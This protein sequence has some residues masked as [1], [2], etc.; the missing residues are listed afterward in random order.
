MEYCHAMPQL[1]NREYRRCEIL[2]QLRNAPERCGPGA[3]D[4]RCARSACRS[5]GSRSPCGT[6]RTGSADRTCG[7]RRTS[8]TCS[9]GP[10][11]RP[12]TCGGTAAIRCRP[13]AGCTAIALRRRTSAAVRRSR[14]SQCHHDTPNICCRRNEQNSPFDQLH[15]LSDPYRQLMLDDHPTHLDDSDDCA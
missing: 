10:A 15:R 4:A 6:C 13:A 5:R 14:S 9:S 12:A 3:R 7:N 8:P 1:R 2:R 11:C